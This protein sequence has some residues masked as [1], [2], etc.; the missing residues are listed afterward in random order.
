MPGFSFI[1]SALREWHAFF[2]HNP[3]NELRG[4]FIIKNQS[5]VYWHWYRSFNCDTFPYFQKKVITFNSLCLQ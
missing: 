5:N 3:D 2:S 1:F 4:R